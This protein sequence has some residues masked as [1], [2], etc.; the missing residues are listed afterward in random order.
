MNWLEKIIFFFL[1]FIFTL[2]T[3]LYESIIILGPLKS[4]S[5]HPNLR[6]S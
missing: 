2:Y 3:S 4:I 1:Y 5:D 6:C